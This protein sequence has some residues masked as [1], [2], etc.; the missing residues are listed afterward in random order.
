MKLIAGHVCVNSGIIVLAD[1][2]KLTADVVDVEVA[3]SEATRL[4]QLFDVKPGTYLIQA[5]IEDTYNGPIE[6]EGV[7][8]I[9]SGT[10]ALV[11]PCYVIED[12]Q[13]VDWLRA[14]DSG[15]NPVEGT[16]VLN[17]M[18]GDG[19]YKVVVELTLQETKK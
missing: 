7:V 18:G 9:P 12:N 14:N 13:W 4:G 5:S 6:V 1:L 19:K 8:D 16:L 2:D 15:N 3:V 11:D 17:Q 10:L